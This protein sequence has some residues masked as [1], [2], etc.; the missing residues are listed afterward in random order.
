[1][2]RLLLAYDKASVRVMHRGNEYY[3][4]GVS[5]GPLSAHFTC[6]YCGKGTVFRIDDEQVR[7]SSCRECGA[8]L[9]N[10]QYHFITG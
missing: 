9:I 8:E 5:D 6:G 7:G 2:E 10:V 4:D 1:M 3:C